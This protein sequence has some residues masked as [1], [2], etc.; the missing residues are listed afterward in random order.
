MDVILITSG[1]LDFYPQ[2]YPQGSYSPFQRLGSPRRER[3][4]LTIRVCLDC[5]GRGREFES[6]R[7]RHSFSPVVMRLFFTLV[8]TEWYPISTAET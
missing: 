3:K 5:H 7:L 1:A 2:I 4:S 6:R 8:E